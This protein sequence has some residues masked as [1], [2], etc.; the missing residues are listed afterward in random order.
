MVL[1]AIIR[2]YLAFAFLGD[3]FP[4]KCGKILKLFSQLFSRWNDAASVLKHHVG[5]V[6]G[7]D[8]ALH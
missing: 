5:H 1:F 6:T 2:F 7:S 3:C 4:E 8:K